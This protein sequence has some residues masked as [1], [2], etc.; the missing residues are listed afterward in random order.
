LE[1]GKEK[2][3]GAE[4][5]EDSSETITMILDDTVPTRRL[6]A[7]LAHLFPRYSRASMERA[8]M[9]GLVFLDDQNVLPATKVKPGQKLTFIPPAPKDLY[10]VPDLNVSIEVL[11]EDDHVLAINKQPDLTMHPGFGTD[12]KPTLAGGLLAHFPELSSVGEMT[13]P[14]LVH[15]LDKDTSGVL[16]VAKTQ[17]SWERLTEAF[18]SREVNKN[19]L[20][21]VK[22]FPPTEETID[23][24]IGRHP[25]QRHTM[26]T[27]E[28]GGRPAK[29]TYRVLKRFRRTG[30]SLVSLRLFTGRTHQAR[31]HLQSR[32]HPILGDKLYGPSLKPLFDDFPSL[33]PLIKRQMLHARRLSLP[34][35]SGG[36]M[37]FAAPWPQDFISLFAELISIENAR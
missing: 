3:D 9:A 4:I 18:S 33:K 19:Y 6:D 20:A 27:V 14:G 2:P 5:D 24:E 31:V 23:K 15:R 26:T 16:V 36:R 34:H 29:T 11:R 13:R 25:V 12:K 37:T 7:L 17:E 21:F 28:E 1:N 10:P 30:V 8:I 32:H 22:G 35:P